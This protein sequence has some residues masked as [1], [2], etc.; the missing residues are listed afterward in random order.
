MLACELHLCFRYF[1]RLFKHDPL[2][3]FGARGRRQGAVVDEVFVC[4]VRQQGAQGEGLQGPA[5]T[6]LEDVNRVGL[7]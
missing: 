7:A 5:F 6:W 3:C 2:H 4:V 1:H